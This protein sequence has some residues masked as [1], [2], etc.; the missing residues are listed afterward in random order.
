[1]P[2]SDLGSVKQ[3]KLKPDMY[4]GTKRYVLFIFL[5]LPR[6]IDLILFERIHFALVIAK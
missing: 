2:I 1:M 6:N 3:C 4:E 5:S